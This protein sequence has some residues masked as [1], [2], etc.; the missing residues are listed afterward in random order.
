MFSEKLT[1]EQLLWVLQREPK[2][3]LAS[4]FPVCTCYLFYQYYQCGCP[5][6]QGKSA[7][8]IFG[9]PLRFR[10]PHH[11]P[12][13]Y[14]C[15]ASR[16]PQL[17]QDLL[18]KRG[19][20]HKHESL[21][22][23]SNIPVELPFPCYQHREACTYTITKKELERRQCY[24]RTAGGAPNC[25]VTKIKRR[26]KVRRE[27]EWSEKHKRAVRK[28]I[29]DNTPLQR[30]NEPKIIHE[31]DKKFAK[32][33]DKIVEPPLHVRFEDQDWFQEEQKRCLL[34]DDVAN[35]ARVADKMYPEIGLLGRGK[36]EL[37]A[38]VLNLAMITSIAKKQWSE[39]G[40]PWEHVQRFGNTG[41]GIFHVWNM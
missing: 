35:G 5:D 40:Y 27:V 17:A 4:Q 6:L 38:S 19:F 31:N 25:K 15:P 12:S 39:R 8:G 34:N 29:E 16:L 2:L 7:I 33:W 14:H 37:G 20:R 36:Y 11:F 3:A 1:E 26:E 13:R 18:Y 23:C 28:F 21:I 41:E 22:S 10:H 30:F 32:T 24:V 9:Q